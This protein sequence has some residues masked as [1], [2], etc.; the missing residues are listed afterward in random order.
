ML[1][2]ALAQIR[3]VPGRPDHNTETMLR[4]IAEGLKASPILNSHLY[5]KH[6]SAKGTIRTFRSIDVNMPTLLPDG[7]MQSLTVRDVG[8]GTLAE[9]DAKVKAL[10]EKSKDPILFAKAQFDVAI[11]QTMQFLAQGK[12]LTVLARLFGAYFGKERLRPV[13]CKNQLQF[14]SV[15]RKHVK[16]MDLTNAITKDDLKEG[17]LVVSNVG[18]IK[19]DLKGQVAM[20]EIVPPQ[21]FAVMVGNLQRRPTVVT[22]ENGDEKVEVRTIL[23]M[24]LAFDHRACDFG[25]L[26]PYIEKLDE[27]FANPAVLNEWK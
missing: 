14:L 24:T 16:G 9:L 21:V 10:V 22:D 3:V 2:I 13:G 19:R 5:Y 11:G 12:I 1:R 23:P 17:T 15:Y 4:C 6:R 26:V 20:F 18:S 8:A 27:I 7:T 25:D